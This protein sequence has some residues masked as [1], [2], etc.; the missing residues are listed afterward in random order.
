M[1]FKEVGKELPETWKPE[2]EG[3]FIEGIYAKRKTQV[4]ANKSNLYYIEVDGVL[5]AVWGSQVLDDKMDDPKIVIGDKIR[6]TYEGK[7]KKYH[8]YKVE[9]DFPEEESEENPV[10]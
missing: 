9:K 3:D 1:V 8:K 7:E 10:N 5:K 4:G 2:N 6:I